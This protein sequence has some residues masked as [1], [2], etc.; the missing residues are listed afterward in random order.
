MDMNRKKYSLLNSIRDT[1]SSFLN[2]EMDFDKAKKHYIDLYHTFENIKN[3]MDMPED[4]NFITSVLFHHN[5]G[6]YSK[7]STLYRVN[8]NGTDII[9]Q[10]GNAHYSEP[11]E[12]YLKSL[13][14]NYK[15]GIINNYTVKENNGL[16]FKLYYT[17]FEY[18]NEML[19]VA[20]LTSS[21]YFDVNKFE[22]LS[23][24]VK[25]LFLRDD[26]NCIRRFSGSAFWENPCTCTRNVKSST[27]R[28]NFVAIK[29]LL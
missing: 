19:C 2:G 5:S 4:Y 29:D 17:F 10:S 1:L 12:K 14:G 18:K 11:T 15:P 13:S 25:R 26:E 3:R 20:S 8:K 24:L 16:K 7:L 28:K 22:I 9:A 23:N 21:V 27:Y 6:N